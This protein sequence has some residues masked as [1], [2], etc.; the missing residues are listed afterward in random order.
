LANIPGQETHIPP[1]EVS[2]RIRIV[3]RESLSED[4]TY[5]GTSSV[6]IAAI[7]T[8]EARMFM[9]PYRLDS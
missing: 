3:H 2:D 6:V 7:I 1:S 9:L 4:A 8:A 5:T